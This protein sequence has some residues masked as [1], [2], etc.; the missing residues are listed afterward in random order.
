VY[1]HYFNGEEEK[2]RRERGGKGRRRRPECKSGL[3]SPSIHILFFDSMVV[4]IY[5]V[6]TDDRVSTGV[7]IYRH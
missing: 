5:F 1:Y 7:I 4:P 2:R 3:T 6:P